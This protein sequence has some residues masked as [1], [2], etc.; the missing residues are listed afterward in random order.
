MADED[1]VVLAKRG[2][3]EATEHL[4][5]KY[6]ALVEC[7]ARTYFLAGADREDV[8]QEGMIG[9]YKAIRDFQNEKL[10]C[11]RA[12][13][14]L[15]VTRQIITA[16]KGAT[17]K[18]HVPLQQYV[19]LQKKCNDGEGDGTLIDVLPNAQVVDPEKLV[20]DRML[21]EAV[22]QAAQTDLSDLESHVLDAYLDGRTYEEMADEFS[23]RTKSI[24][25][26]LQRAKRKIGEKVLTE[27]A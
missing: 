24:D 16:V 1:V 10:P 25:N 3:D 15:C 23:C 20:M 8:V 4:L 13:A 2:N 12:F 18:K 6:R 7:K 17:R 26:A 27:A 9:L 14:D 19:S 11:F 5:S 21:T 22:K